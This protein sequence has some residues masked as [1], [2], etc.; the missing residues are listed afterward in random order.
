MCLSQ[1]FLIF[2]KNL[3]KLLKKE[4]HEVIAVSTKYELN[5]VNSNISNLDTSIFGCTYT[6]KTK[7]S[8]ICFSSAFIKT[9]S[10]KSLKIF[11]K[12]S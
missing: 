10:S 11:R 3:L 12:K 2:T 9:T 8:S 4:K 7:L 5:G 1:S 6:I